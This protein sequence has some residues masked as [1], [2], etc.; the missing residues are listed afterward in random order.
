M[1]HVM[2]R[3]MTC[4]NLHKNGVNV[5]GNKSHKIHSDLITKGQHSR[6]E[7]ASLDNVSTAEWWNVRVCCQQGSWWSAKHRS[8][9][10]TWW[11]GHYQPTPLQLDIAARVDVVTWS[12]YHQPVCSPTPAGPQQSSKTVTSFTQRYQSNRR[13][14]YCLSSYYSFVHCACREQHLTRWRLS[15][16]IAPNSY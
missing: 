11:P 13:S 3:C 12:S 1:S 2:F 9:R 15:I 16:F 5:T 8:W 10:A 6:E 4:I 14:Y 7:Y